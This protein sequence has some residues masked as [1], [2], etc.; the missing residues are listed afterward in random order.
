MANAVE[1]SSYMAQ[2]YL[3]YAL[4]VI[5]DRAIPDARD[6]L[7]PVQRRILYS[8]WQM[9]LLPSSAHRK[10]ARIVGEVL[11]KYHPHGDAAVYM[12][13][14]RMAQGFVSRYPL[15]DGHGNF[16]SIDGDPPAAMRYTEARLSTYGESF[17][18]DL[19]HDTVM[20]RPNFDGS[21]N[22][23]VV[24]PAV[25]PNLLANGATGIAV[26]LQTNI[27]PHNVGELIDALIY[28][29]RNPDCTVDD[30][31]QYVK[32][33]DFPTGGV[34]IGSDGIR[35]VYTTGEGQIVIRGETEILPGSRG[36]Q[37][38][39]IRSVPYMTNKAELVEEIAKLV[40][41]GKL[42]GVDDVRDESD[43]EGIRIVLELKRNTD[44][45]YILNF[46][47]RYTGLQQNFS[48]RMIALVGGRP[49]TL[50][51]KDALSEYLTFKQHVVLKRAEHGVRKGKEKL[52]VLYAMKKA[53]DALDDVIS[54]IRASKNAE[55]ARRRLMDFLQIDETQARAILDMTLQRL[56]GAEITKILEE[57]R[58]TEQLVAEFQ[59][60]IDQP[61]KLYAQVEKELLEAKA[62]FG[63]KR[64]TTILA[65]EKPAQQLVKIEQVVDKSPVIVSLSAAGYIK[66]HPNVDVHK[67]SQ[68]D[69]PRILVS[70]TNADRA[71][72]FTSVGNVY[73]FAVSNV[74]KHHGTARGTLVRRIVQIPTSHD[75]VGFVLAG[76]H[77]KNARVFMSTAKGFIK[78][79]LL[80]EYIA[81]RTMI[82]GINLE[83]GDQ[84]VRAWIPDNDDEFILLTTKQHMGIL[85]PI[86]QVPVTGRVTRGVIGIRLREGDTVVSANSLK[87]SDTILILGTNG[88][89]ARYPVSGLSHQNRGGK[90]TRKVPRTM[91]GHFVFPVRTGQIG[92]FTA[93]ND[94]V[95]LDQNTVSG[96]LWDIPKK[97]RGQEV[98]LAWEIPGAASILAETATDEPEESSSP[99]PTADSSPGIDTSG[100]TKWI[101]FTTKE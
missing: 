44:A 71:L 55:D 23:P 6:G 78:S 43:H 47:Y 10:S 41:S 72:L 29:Q 89:I 17:L 69:A 20:F 101:L 33:P 7:K 60:I 66:N 74:E 52:H 53:V 87:S 18:H 54:I 100:Q 21:L 65:S 68:N 86:D 70:G 4:S 61:E 26:G 94:F 73:G 91:P 88:Q 27:P 1:Y 38:L 75:I 14:V 40:D 5:T 85:F 63:D 80:E 97:L 3:Q 56:I 82:Q 28:L 49:K 92:V 98:I 8:A 42:D 31:M 76:E 2:N 99:T 81:Q 32:G 11:G 25:I 64:R 30:L 79:T 34:I 77:N 45:N 84:L 35:K 67:P 9:G 57:I 62:K 36:K 51:L 93:N 39:I 50:T 90:G 37:D 24:L 95:V 46:L 19:K 12:A 16:G 58:T 22:E 83:E 59:A 15:I 48:V 96:K 13:M